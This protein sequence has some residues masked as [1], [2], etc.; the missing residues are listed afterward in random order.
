KTPPLWKPN[1]DAPVSFEVE[2]RLHHKAAWEMFSTDRRNYGRSGT[3]LAPPLLLSPLLIIPKR[4]EAGLTNSGFAFT[5]P[6]QAISH[7]IT[8]A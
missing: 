5:L 2:C 8:V 3:N 6:L 4:F 7:K 1:R